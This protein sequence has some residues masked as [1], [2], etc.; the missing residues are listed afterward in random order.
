MVNNLKDTTKTISVR[1]ESK[2]IRVHHCRLTI[3]TA[4]TYTRIHI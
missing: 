4:C 2:Y 3:Y 1:N